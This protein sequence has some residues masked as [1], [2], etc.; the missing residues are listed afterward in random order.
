MNQRFIYR[1]SGLL[2]ALLVSVS[3]LKPVVALPLIAAGGH[4][5][6][7]TA[8]FGKPASSG[9]GTGHGFPAYC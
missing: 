8:D 2:L 6:Q 1:G 9:Q 5:A 3:L 4:V 7:E